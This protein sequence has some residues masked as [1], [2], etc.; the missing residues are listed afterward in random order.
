MI[1]DIKR[2]GKGATTIRLTGGSKFLL[3]GDTT[4]YEFAYESE[5]EIQEGLEVTALVD[6]KET[7][8]TIMS[9]ST[10]KILIKFEGSQK[11]TIKECIIK[12]DNT[13]L[14]K[15]LINFSGN[16]KSE[17]FINEC[18]CGNISQYKKIISEL[19]INTFN[20]ILLLRICFRSEKR[21]PMER[22]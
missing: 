4:C 20:Q 21:I 17:N 13:S 7:A 11:R 18:L 22:A 8:G 3:E 1:Q 2:T 10:E 14:I 16:H 15:S 19:Y 5:N 9:V 6:G 12:I